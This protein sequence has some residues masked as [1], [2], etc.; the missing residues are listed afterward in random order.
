MTGVP[1]R[2][3]RGRAGEWVHVYRDR[4]VRLVAGLPFALC[5]AVA[6]WQRDSVAASIGVRPHAVN[7][8]KNVRSVAHLPPSGVRA[9]FLA[10]ACHASPCHGNFCRGIEWAR[11][12]R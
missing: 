10:L 5:T 4:C 8:K 12:L 7:T 9:V 6:R 2:L 1:L 3:Q 11:D